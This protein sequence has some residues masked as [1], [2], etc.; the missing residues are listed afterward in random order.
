MRRFRLRHPIFFFLAA[1]FIAG[2]QLFFFTAVVKTGVAIGTIVGIGSA[3]I[4][5]GLLGFLFRGEELGRRWFLA[6]GLAISGCAL[7]SLTGDAA[8]TV[9]SVGMLLAVGAGAC[10]AAFTLVLKALL[11]DNPA[12]S[13]IAVIFC[14]GALLLT[15]LLLTAD[16]EWLL[17][18]R[19]MFVVLHLGV[20]ATAF[21][22][23]LFAWGLRTTPVSTATTLSLA[24]PV[25]AAALGF[26][27]LGEKVNLQTGIGIVLV[28]AGLVVLIRTRR[29]HSRG[30]M[31]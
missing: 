5:G 24:E 25:T 27:L 21:P 9:D 6:T 28:F 22:Y 26:A 12:V 16:S 13:V 3:P 30:A 14:L 20:A 8:V 23:L 10:Y 18:P 7:L 4:A 2:Y 15:P 11:P 17:Q 1:L 31:Q 19:A 29:L